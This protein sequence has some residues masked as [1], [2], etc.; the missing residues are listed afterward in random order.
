MFVWEIILKIESD[1]L[2]YDAKWL[3]INIELHN[4]QL[5]QNI[6]PMPVAMGNILV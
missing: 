5:I 4:S 1:I 2:Y 3:N 6:D